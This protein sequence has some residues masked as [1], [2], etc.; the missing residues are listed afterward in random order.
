MV[1]RQ[2]L[3]TTAV[4]PSEDVDTAHLD[5]VVLWIERHGILALGLVGCG[6]P[7]AGLSQVGL[8]VENP[9]FTLQRETGPQ[10]KQKEK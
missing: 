9:V 5:G 2:R 7:D 8:L 6:H 4:S 3:W 10:G 1:S